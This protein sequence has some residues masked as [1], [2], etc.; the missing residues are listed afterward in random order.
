MV[1]AP[2]WRWLG[3]TDEEPDP[4]AAVRQRLAELEGLWAV[5]RDR[6]AAFTIQFSFEIP[7]EEPWGRLSMALRAAGDE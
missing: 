3:F 6:L 4:A 1:I 5:C 2:D 7:P